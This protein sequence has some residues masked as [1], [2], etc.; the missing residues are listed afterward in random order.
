LVILIT[1]SSANRR[2][3]KSYER[4]MIDHVGAPVLHLDACDKCG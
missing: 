4:D 2:V 3:A 1:G